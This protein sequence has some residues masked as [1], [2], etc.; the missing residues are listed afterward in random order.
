MPCDHTRI[1]R[2][3]GT[4]TFAA[5]RGRL[6][7]VDSADRD[8]G[9]APEGAGDPAGDDALERVL[10]QLL[11]C[12]AKKDALRAWP[13]GV[14]VDEAL[15]KAP[16]VEARRDDDGT[17]GV[18]RFYEIVAHDPDS[19]RQLTVAQAKERIDALAGERV[20][21]GDEVGV[22]LPLARL[23]AI[24]LADVDALLA[25]LRAGEP[26]P[27]APS[28]LPTAITEQLRGDRALADLV[29]ARLAS[30]RGTPPHV[31]LRRVVTNHG[32]DVVLWTSVTS[33]EPVELCVLVARGDELKLVVVP[34]ATSAAGHASLLRALA[35]APGERSLWRYFEVEG[36]SLL[37]GAEGALWSEPNA[38]AGSLGR[39]LSLEV[40]ALA[41]ARDPTVYGVARART[42]LLTWVGERIVDEVEELV[43]LPLDLPRAV[44][45]GWPEGEAL[46]RVQAAARELRARLQKRLAALVDERQPRPVDALGGAAVLRVLARAA[47]HASLDASAQDGGAEPCPAR[48]GP[49]SD[50]ELHVR[51]GDVVVG[52]SPADDVV[53]ART[54]AGETDLFVDGALVDGDVEGWRAL[55]TVWARALALSDADVELAFD[56]SDDES[57]DG[58]GDGE[59]SADDAETTLLSSWLLSL[60]EREPKEMR[61]PPRAHAADSALIA[62]ALVDRFVDRGPL[63]PAPQD[64]ARNERE[65]GAA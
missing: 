6:R 34:A 50:E 3:T 57:G 56:A 1:A 22:E 38:E 58:D 43:G 52:L 37:C 39:R 2:V 36:P 62:A 33:T 17:L 18:F 63:A 21:V 10:E 40:K 32:G 11:E 4:F 15:A 25:E 27:D 5:V 47:A 31:P 13:R 51:F 29:V 60:G 35:P 64:D 61:W 59:E 28:L 54:T 55:A 9:E 20:K 19:L 42:R 12:A 45:T 53:R 30:L 44:E 8:E 26:A 41:I 46:A 48:E 65:R 7:L 49:E 16:L 23:C 14:S 24:A